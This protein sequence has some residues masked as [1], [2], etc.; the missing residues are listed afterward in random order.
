M[1][2]VRPEIGVYAERAHLVAYLATQYPAAMAY[3]DPAEPDWPV[4]YIDSPKG[5]L[6][7]HISPDDLWLFAHVPVKR[8]DMPRWDGHSTEEK[9]QRLRDLVR[10][11]ANE[12]GL[13]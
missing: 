7:W 2:D 6:T 3:N 9:Y 5:Q 13:V 4:L 10:D 1:A 11:L 8:E 12:K